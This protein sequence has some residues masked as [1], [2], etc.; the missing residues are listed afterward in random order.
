MEFLGISDKIK[1]IFTCPECHQKKYDTISNVHNFGFSCP[2]CSDGISYPEKFVANVFSVDE[3]PTISMRMNDGVDI[4]PLPKNKAFL[5]QLLN[6]A[7]TGPIFG[8]LMGAC[9]GPSVFLWIVFGSVLGGA[10]HD[11]MS[12]MVSSRNDG[13]S[14]VELVGKYCG[15][16]FVFTA[17]EQEFFGDRE[18][19][20]F[21]WD[22]SFIA[23][24]FR[25]NGFNVKAASRQI[26]EKRRITKFE[27]QKWF[28]P[29]ESAYGSKMVFGKRCIHWS[30]I[31]ICCHR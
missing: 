29:Q 1:R 5:I 22:A 13:K 6:I 27:I 31:L 3:R 2:H 4:V 23:N 7:G 16:A 28:N 11:Y 26:K 8:P 9:F 19:P 20:L 14:I 17:G 12:G 10:V 30:Q 15:K 24:T 18:N 21:T 25:K